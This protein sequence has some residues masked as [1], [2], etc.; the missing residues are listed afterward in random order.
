M[1]ACFHKRQFLLPI[2]AFLP[3]FLDPRNAPALAIFP[4]VMLAVEGMYFLNEE[5]EKAYLRTT[6]KEGSVISSRIATGILSVMLLYLFVISYLSV[7][8][9]VRVGLT[10]SDRATME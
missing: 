6:Q 7:G 1:L 8:N 3:F 4:L 9:L 2:W 5:F 10:K